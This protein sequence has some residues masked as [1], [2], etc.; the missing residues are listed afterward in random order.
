MWSF[1]QDTSYTTKVFPFGGKWTEIAVILPQYETMQYKN[2][3]FLLRGC[4]HLPVEVKN[5]CFPEFLSVAVRRVCGAAFEM[6]NNKIRLPVPTVEPAI[7]R[8]TSV[9]GTDKLIS[10]VRVLVE[11]REFTLTTM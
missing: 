9:S 7:G 11:G 3:L 8:G 4:H 1:Q 6:L 10:P 2:T 5:C